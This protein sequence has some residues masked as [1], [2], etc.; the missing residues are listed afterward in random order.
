MSEYET[1]LYEMQGNVALL[2]LNRPD[3]RNAMNMELNRELLAGFERAASDDQVRAVLVTGAGKGFCAGADLAMS[4]SQPTAD[5][6]YEIIVSSYQPMMK[7]VT[8]MKKPVIAAING[9]AAGAGASLALAC[10][11]RLMAHDASIMM[12][13]SN[14]ALVPDA[15]ATWFLTQL[16]GYSR[17]Y[18]IAIEGS[19][20]PAERCL[21]L[22]LTN[23]IVPAEQLMMISI[24]WAKKLAERP[25]L[26]LGLTKHAMQY[27]Q[28]HDLASTIEYEAQLQKETVVSQDF[29]EGVMAFMQKREPR[30]QGK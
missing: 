29:I 6:A 19:R 25:T 24:A 30:F 9:V 2:T 18:E 8:R 16:V 7:A 13:F 22:G 17:A 10:D 28:L 3:R 23:K 20:V 5:Q 12:A 21:E 11:L 26:A 14:I 15:G 1:I 27:A 4:Q